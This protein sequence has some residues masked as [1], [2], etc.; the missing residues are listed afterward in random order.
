[1]VRRRKPTTLSEPETLAF[2][3]DA[4]QLHA[5]ICRPLISPP[6]GEHY[7]ALRDLNQAISA[8]VRTV[9]GQEPEWTG[10]SSSGAV[11]VCRFEK[12]APDR[13]ERP[14]FCTAPQIVTPAARV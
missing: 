7:R 9:T 4:E 2:L 5:T 14:V 3:R 13:S 12:V 8:A 1:M 6:Q 10:R 11:S